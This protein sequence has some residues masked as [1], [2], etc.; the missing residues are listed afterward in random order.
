[1][2][3]LADD[4]YETLFLGKVNAQIEVSAIKFA[5]RHLPEPLD[6]AVGVE[7]IQPN[8]ALSG[9]TCIFGKVQP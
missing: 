6:A 1:M 2:S 5:G 7:G 9:G 4:F 8:I 3:H